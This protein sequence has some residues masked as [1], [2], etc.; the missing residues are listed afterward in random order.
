MRPH[1]SYLEKEFDNSSNFK[2]K[3]NPCEGSFKASHRETAWWL[4]GCYSTHSVL[5]WRKMPFISTSHPS[6]SLPLAGIP[7]QSP[8][9][10]QPALLN[11][12]D[13]VT[14]MLIGWQGTKRIIN[15]FLG[16]WSTNRSDPDITEH[17]SAFPRAENES[18]LQLWFTWEWLTEILLC[19]STKNPSQ[20]VRATQPSSH[21]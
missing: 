6:P 20:L 13:L 2:K 14:P 17:S 4:T 19:L 15:V 21:L 10:I 3:K 12:R 8:N 16:P 9:P 7:G 5:M 11:L 1:L 18:Q